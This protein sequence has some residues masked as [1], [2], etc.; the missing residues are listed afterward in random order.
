MNVN[1][2]GELRLVGS[3]G[4]A[5]QDGFRVLLSARLITTTN[6]MEVKLRHIWAD[7]VTVEG[8]TLPPA[9]TDVMLERGNLEIF[10]AVQRSE[11]RRATL[12]FDETIREAELLSMIQQKP[13]RS[14]LGCRELRE[15]VGLE[16]KEAAL[17]Q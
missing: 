9:G 1:G 2:G 8:F 12:V 5:R 10:G 14:R 16:S 3:D 4:L 11:G 15:E 7:G 17:W 13:I 6:Q